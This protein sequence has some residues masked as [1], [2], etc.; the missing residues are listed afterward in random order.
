[1]AGPTA[2]TFSKRN[3]VNSSS[4]HKATLSEAHIEFSMGSRHTRTGLLLVALLVLAM[5]LNTYRLLLLGLAGAALVGSCILG[6]TRWRLGIRQER[7]GAVT[8]S[9]DIRS[10]RALVRAVLDRS[11]G[12]E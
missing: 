3:A 6:C 4:H 11:Q 12:S 2:G 8:M 1:M 9:H 7:D 10:F 5:W